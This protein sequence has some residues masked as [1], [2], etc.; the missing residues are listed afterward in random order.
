MTFLPERTLPNLLYL[1]FKWTTSDQ[2]LWRSKDHRKRLSAM[3]AYAAGID[4][5]T[6]VLPVSVI[7]DR[8]RTLDVEYE[9]IR[10]P[11]GI[12]S[13]ITL[14]IVPQAYLGYTKREME[15]HTT[16]KKF[17]PKSV[18]LGA[19]YLERCVSGAKMD[20]HIQSLRCASGPAVV[21]KM[22]QMFT[23]CAYKVHGEDLWTWDEVRQRVI[24]TYRDIRIKQMEGNEQ[25]SESDG[26]GEA[27]M[28]D[29]IV[30]CQVL[31]VTQI[32]VEKEKPT[33]KSNHK[34]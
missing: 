23:D 10:F 26:D 6:P 11:V 15:R 32:L 12:V 7:I 17:T 22:Q 1:P 19:S 20:N 28:S 24:E 14:C 16:H 2:D 30:K 25:E 34:T 3:N 27:G 18:P 8:G 13:P 21:H 5:D 29:L 9:C 4:A 33:T 31:R